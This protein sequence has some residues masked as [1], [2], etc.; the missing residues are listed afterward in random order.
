LSDDRSHRPGDLLVG[1]RPVGNLRRI[2]DGDPSLHERKIA[3]D[4]VEQRSELDIEHRR[5]RVRVLE[6]VRHLRGPVSVVD[7]GW[8]HDLALTA[9]AAGDQVVGDAVGPGVELAPRKL[10]FPRHDHRPLG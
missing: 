7:V 6:E 8:C 3:A 10:P 9:D 1:H 2:S 4:R 5:F